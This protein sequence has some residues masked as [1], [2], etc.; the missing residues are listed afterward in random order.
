MHRRLRR[1]VHKS[2]ATSAGAGRRPDRSQI[3]ACAVRL[4]VEKGGLPRSRCDRQAR[5]GTRRC[6]AFG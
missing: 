3:D 1:R 4:R 5:M 2:P 6:A